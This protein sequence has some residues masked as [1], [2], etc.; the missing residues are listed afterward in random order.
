MAIVPWREP[1]GFTRAE[2]RHHRFAQGGGKMGR[3]RVVAEHR[4]GAPQHSHEGQKIRCWHFAG[5]FRGHGLGPLRKHLDQFEFL[6]DPIR[7]GKFAPATERPLFA[8]K[9]GLRVYGEHRAPVASSFS[10]RAGCRN[11]RHG[12]IAGKIHCPGD[13]VPA[14]QVCLPRRLAMQLLGE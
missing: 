8:R 4:V 2:N 5:V 13:L 6:R 7:S 1:I 12:N 14:M 11:P 10:R 3:K 9:A